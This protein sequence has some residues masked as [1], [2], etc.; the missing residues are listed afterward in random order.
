MNVEALLGGE[1][2]NDAHIPES[3]KPANN[4]TSYI[5]IMFIIHISSYIIT[6]VNWVRGNCG[7]S[8]IQTTVISLLQLQCEKNKLMTTAF[9]LLSYVEPCP[10]S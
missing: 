10:V 6:V 1:E 7:N 9:K 5:H 2:K 8:A 4:C 3:E